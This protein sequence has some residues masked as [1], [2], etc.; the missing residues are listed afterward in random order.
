MEN[1]MKTSSLTPELELI[2]AHFGRKFLRVLFLKCKFIETLKFW[3]EE[4]KLQLPIDSISLAVCMGCNIVVLKYLKEKLSFKMI[5][6]KERK[7][8]INR[9]KRFHNEG[10]SFLESEFN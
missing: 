10:I 1:M 9:G 8:L 3:F 4:F 2:I 5:S 7:N 6:K